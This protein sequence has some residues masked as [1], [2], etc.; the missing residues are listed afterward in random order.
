MDSSMAFTGGLTVYAAVVVAIGYLINAVSRRTLFNPWLG[1]LAALAM[2][3]AGHTRLLLH[4]GLSP[5]GD[6]FNQGQ[7][8]GHYVAGPTWEP[9]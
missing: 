6:A 3:G 8:F 4:R 7:L 5:S 1:G 9:P 2:L